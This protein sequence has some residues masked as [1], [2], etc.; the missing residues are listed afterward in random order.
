MDLKR[1]DLSKRDAWEEALAPVPHGFCHRW[2]H[3]HALSLSG[4]EPFLLTG[5]EAAVLLVERRYGNWVDVT[6][7][8]GFAGPAGGFDEKEFADAIDKY[9][10]KQR[11]VAGYFALHPQFCHWERLP[12]AKP[13]RTLFVVDLAPSTN[14]LWR[15]LDGKSMRSDTR[16]PSGWTFEWNREY[17]ASDFPELYRSTCA[18]VGASR[19]YRFSDET[20]AAYG[21]MEGFLWA[22]ARNPAGALVSVAGFGASEW[23]AE[24][25]FQAS[26][27]EG[28][29]ATGALLWESILRLKDLGLPWLNLGGGAVEGDGLEKFKSRFGGVP[30]RAGGWSRVFDPS[31]Y[32]AACQ[33]RGVPAEVGAGAEY[34][35]AYQAPEARP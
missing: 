3:A 19:V 31:A 28:R 12:Q 27:P 11:W 5:G 24:Y 14:D 2:D 6:T 16:L 15:G 8:Y 10:K 21:R 33:R 17:I 9:A 26:S 35:P 20:L 25:F 23:G 18:R 1:I 30:S 29:G 22:G 13:A 34:F 7:P 32:L 4:I